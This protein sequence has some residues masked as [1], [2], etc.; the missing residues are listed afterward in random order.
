M[1]I[2]IALFIIILFFS[3]LLRKKTETNYQVGVARSAVQTRI[4]LTN[5]LDPQILPTILE[6]VLS[7]ISIQGKNGKIDSK[8][9]QKTVVQNL[10]QAILSNSETNYRVDLNEDGIIDPLMILPESVDGEAVIY[11]LRV[12]DPEIFPKDPQGDVDWDK[13]AKDQSLEIIE[14]VMTLTQSKEGV[15]IASKPNSNVYQNTSNQ[16]SY[17]QH[18]PST[19]YNW[20][21]TY[22]QYRLFS[23]VLF[24]SYGWGFG[25][26]Y[27][28]FYGSH[29][30]PVRTASRPYRASSYKK[31]PKSSSSLKSASGKNIRSQKTTNRSNSSI[32]S[33]K[34]KRNLGVRQSNLGS[35]RSGGFGRQKTSYRSNSRS[36]SSFFSGGG[37]RGG[38]GK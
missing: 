17:Q 34:S 33:L 23:A 12:P 25:G 8:E 30:S 28:G 29:Y 14:L 1:K 5:Q 16:T 27:G 19:S 36:R 31:A 13:I 38:W 10:S 22:F 2:F 3:F 32:R 9:F 21:Q 24:G 4:D 37:S 6:E 7:G 20:I 35:T 11:S 26:F 18:Y 15:S